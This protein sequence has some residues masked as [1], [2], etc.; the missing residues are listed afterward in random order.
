MASATCALV[1]PQM[2]FAAKSEL[3]NK[4]GKPLK[5]AQQL[6]TS[7]NFKDALAKVKEVDAMPGKNAAEEQIVNDM[8]AVIY[9]STKDF[10]SLMALYETMLNKNAFTPDVK[11]TRLK[12]MSQGYL[13]LKN[14]P[15]A[16]TYSEQYL[17]EVGADANISMQIAQIYLLQKDYA[18]AAEIAGKQVKAS[19]ASGKPA[20]E[21]WYKVWKSAVYSQNKTAEY[22]DVL[23]QTVAAYPTTAY[24]GEMITYV[25]KESTFND[26]QTIIMTRLIDA[27]GLG[28]D[29]TYIAM[30]ELSLAAAN[31]GDAKAALEKGMALGLIKG[32]RE[33]KLLAKA[34][35][36]AAG[37]LTSLANIEKQA[38]AAPNGEALVKI[39][40]GYLGHGQFEKAIETINKGLTKGG[41]SFKDEATINLGLAYLG[42][43]KTPE[44]I[45][46]FK[47]VP[48]TSKVARVS[49]LWAIQAT[50]PAKP[51][52]AAPAA[53]PAAPAKT[54]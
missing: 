9:S 45:K 24:W 51:A 41:V 19:S 30:A 6:I 18:K 35:A 53:A 5:E 34:T 16:L 31:P 25:N 3:S 22:V 26:R 15:K 39:G 4:V 23:E 2:A 46:A 28:T 33:K 40:E 44:A 48:A 29:K 54:K 1:A 27:V 37:D 38:A 12:E 17:K 21:D 10:N 8:L 49:R 13:Y 50:N 36:D 32:E 47:S 7:K 14:Y 52:A 43:K 20:S 11:K 42:A